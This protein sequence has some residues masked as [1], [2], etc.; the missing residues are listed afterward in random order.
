MATLGRLVVHGLAMPL[1]GLGL[2]AAGLLPRLEFNAVSNAS[3]GEYA[4]AIGGVI[5]GSTSESVIGRL[6][7]PTI[8]YP[9]AAVLALA[10]VGILLGRGRFALPFWLLTALGAIVLTIPVVTPLHWLLY[11]LPR[12]RQLHEH[13]PERVILVAFPGLA[14]MAGAGVQVLVDGARAAGSAVLR[15][16]AVV[17]PGL[18]LVA[19]AVRGGSVSGIAVAGVVAVA[20]VSLIVLFGDRRAAEPRGGP[21]VQP[22]VWRPV[23]WLPAALVLVV[24]ADLLLMNQALAGQGP[25]GGFHR[26]HLDAYYAPSGAAAFLQERYERDG[27]FRFAGYDPAVG[28]IE[29]GQTVLYRYQFADPITRELVVNNRATMLGLEDAQ[30][31][32]PLQVAA[33]VDLVTAMNGA[34]QEYH[35]ADVF[36]PG[37]ASPLLDLLGIRYLVIPSV[38]DAGRADLTSLVAT[39]ATVYDD[40]T[41]RVV[42]NPEALSRVWAVDQTLTVAP[43]NALPLLAG[44]QVDPRT[45]AVFEQG[46]GPEPP[47]LPVPDRVTGAAPPVLTLATSDDPDTIRFTSSAAT[48]VVVLLSEMAYPAWTAQIDGRATDVLT[49]DHALRAVV[50]PAGQ[51]EVVLRYDS[52]A[53]RSGLVITLATVVVLVGSWLGTVWWSRRG[54]RLTSDR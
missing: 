19:F 35:G 42:E 21:G 53:T 48:D 10:V 52:P 16:A 23:R 22:R 27:P 39:W 5:G 31:Y 1:A 33:Y 32:N 54:R 41:T 29:N 43:G 11:L 20:L 7:Q 18:I 13:W 50:V 30:G 37:L 36:P 4:T 3:G 47:A 49:A 26:Q 25:F 38:F 15:G 46:V 24:A 14:L 51:H 6:F 17:L 9:G 28:V 40:G 2:S 8:Y 44:G 45:T 34:A 12:F